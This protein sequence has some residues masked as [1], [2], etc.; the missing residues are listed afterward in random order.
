MEAYPVKPEEV[1]SMNYVSELKAENKEKIFKK[2]HSCSWE[3]KHVVSD[4]FSLTKQQKFFSEIDDVN[5]YDLIYFDAFGP[6]KQPDLWTKEIFDK[7]Y[8]ALKS[9]GV[10]VTYASK[11]NVKRAIRAAGFSLKRLPGPLGK[12]HMLRATKI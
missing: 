5:K 2:I 3:K 9:K 4:K 11:G 7:M 6:E 8:A 10:L 12:W 1:V